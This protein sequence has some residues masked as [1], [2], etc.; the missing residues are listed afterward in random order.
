MAQCRCCVH[1]SPPQAAAGEQVRVA[2]LGASGYTGEEVVRL[3]ALHPTFR[4]TTLTGDRQAGKVG[5]C[6]RAWPGGRHTSDAVTPAGSTPGQTPNVRAP[7]WPAHS[8]ADRAPC[9]PAR[10]AALTRRPQHPSKT[11]PP[12]CV[13]LGIP[14]GPAAQ[15][16]SEVFPHLLTARDVPPLVKIED[17]AWDNVDAGGCAAAEALVKSTQEQP[18]QTR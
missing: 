6:R 3:L 11:A 2:V 1:V 5:G 16:F 17:V 14:S 9:L 12:P 15:H 18:V 4:V 8:R 10:T 13:H 7:G